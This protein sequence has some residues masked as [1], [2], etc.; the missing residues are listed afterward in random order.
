MGWLPRRPRPNNSPE[1]SLW[2]EFITDTL[3]C[4][5]AWVVDL[6]E[7]V[8]EAYSSW[9]TYET[10]AETNLRFKEMF[11]GNPLLGLVK[12]FAFEEMP[13]DHKEWSDETTIRGRAYNE[14]E[15]LRSLEFMESIVL[16]LNDYDLQSSIKCFGL[17]ELLNAPNACTRVSSLVC[18]E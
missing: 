9:D 14:H 1:I 15:H 8:L 11:E 12:E 6:D 2:F 4:E 3:F 16:K 18:K 10:A 13:E 7:K 17:R 5:W